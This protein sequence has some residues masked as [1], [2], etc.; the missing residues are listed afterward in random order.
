[1]I[2][3]K[4]AVRALDYS[5]DI[6]LPAVPQIGSFISLPRPDKPPIENLVTVRQVRWELPVGS[7][8]EIFVECDGGKGSYTPR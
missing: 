5:L 2:R 4:I 6:D 8:P 1:M 3:V 7:Q